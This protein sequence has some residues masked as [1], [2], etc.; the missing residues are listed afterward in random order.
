MSY[1]MPGAQGYNYSQSAYPNIGGYAT[2]STYP[3]Y[4]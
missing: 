4:K 1:G 2:G 3:T